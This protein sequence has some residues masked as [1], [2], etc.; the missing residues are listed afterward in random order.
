[1]R[2]VKGEFFRLTVP[3]IRLLIVDSGV[4]RRTSVAV[5]HVNSLVQSEKEKYITVLSELGDLSDGFC[6]CTDS[7]KEIFAVN[8]F[9]KAETLLESLDLS[10]PEIA[11]I[12]EIANANG[13]SAKMSGAGRGG[14]VLV[15]G[16]QV[17]EKDHLFEEF[18]HLRVI[19][20]NEGLRS[21]PV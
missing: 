20:D 15:A 3:P 11:R 4:S 2:Y 12:V 8:N 17:F 6:S 16:E 18:R 21:E 1:M 14:V 5:T 13:L 10:C 9:N 19:V 7:E